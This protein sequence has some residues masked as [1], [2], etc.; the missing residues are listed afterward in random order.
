[1]HEAG[2]LWLIRY[3]LPSGAL[4]WYIADKDQLNVNDGANPNPNRNSNPNPNPNPTPNPNPNQVRPAT[5]T[6]GSWT[7]SRTT[8]GATARRLGLASPKASPSPSLNKTTARRRATKDD[9]GEDAGAEAEQ[10]GARFR[11]HPC[12]K[13]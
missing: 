6:A 4:F 12:S 8:S 9:L 10:K 13:L 7:R 11:K 1:M 2:Q 5:P 3:R